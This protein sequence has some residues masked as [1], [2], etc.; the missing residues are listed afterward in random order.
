M[1]AALFT[2]S[3]IPDLT[4]ARYTTLGVRGVDGVLDTHLGFLRL[5]VSRPNTSLH[6]F[7][8]Y[9]PLRQDGVDLHRELG[10][11]GARGVPGPCQR[12][13]RRAQVDGPHRLTPAAQRRERR[14][15]LLE[16]LEVQVRGVVQ[17]DPRRLRAVEQEQDPA[18]A[19]LKLGGRQRGA[20]RRRGKRPQRP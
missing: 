2:L 12:A 9:D 8:S 15:H 3:S 5:F 18:V 1:L 7:Y 4:L 11:A 14:V 6:L 19:H 20:H 10:R 16:I 13:P 17:V